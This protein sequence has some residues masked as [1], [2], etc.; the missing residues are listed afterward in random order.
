LQASRNAHILP[1]MLRFRISLRLG[2]GRDLL[3]LI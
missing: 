3:F 2:I 1:C